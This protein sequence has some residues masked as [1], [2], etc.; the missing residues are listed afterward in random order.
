MFAAGVLGVL[1]ALPIG[2][3]AP[4]AA[5]DGAQSRITIR[6]TGNNLT[7]E[8]SDGSSSP[9]LALGNPVA[10]VLVEAVR[11]KRAGTSDDA[12]VWYLRAHAQE[13]PS[14]IDYDTVS[15]LRS[16]G[17]GRN[18]V[19]YLSGVAAVEIGPTGAVGG[20]GPGETFEGPPEP[21]MSNEL[22]VGLAYGFAGSAGRA[23]R[24]FSGRPAMHETFRTAPMA[25]PRVPSVSPNPDRFPRH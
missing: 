5:S 20:P 6:G 7:I 3:A 4:P 8:S 16:A 14:F 10:P 17:A 22:P 2:I 12:L 24:R 23:R 25:G 19:A 9:R 1:L 11:M 13:I 21:E 18:V 15:R